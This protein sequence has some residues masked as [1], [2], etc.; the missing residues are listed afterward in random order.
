MTWLDLAE[1]QEMLA[2]AW[3]LRARSKPTRLREAA[4]DDAADAAGTAASYR[5]AHDNGAKLNQGLAEF[6]SVVP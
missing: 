3:T 5:M 1:Q 2:K 6:L 4:L